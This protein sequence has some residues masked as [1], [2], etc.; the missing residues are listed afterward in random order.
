MRIVIDT[1]DTGPSVTKRILDG[2]T[3]FISRSTLLKLE[4]IAF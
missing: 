3:I 2:S 1:G 4:I